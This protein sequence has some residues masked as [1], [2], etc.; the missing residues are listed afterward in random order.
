MTDRTTHDGGCACRAVR[1]QV[2]GA[3]LF[4]HACHCSWCQ[5]ETG[6]AFAV[7]ALTE[8]DRIEVT[9]AT[10]DVV[11]TPSASGEGQKILRCPVC[12]V[13]VWS[14]YA[15]A[16]GD[17][18]SFLRV[19]TLDDPAVM[20]PDIHIFTST[21]Q[22]WLTLPADA[23]AVPEYYNRRQFWPAASVERFNAL[24]GD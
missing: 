9:G 3:P 10:P 6:A 24:R 2:H 18:V 11:L 5:R 4:V 15:M 7:N 12:R 13:A 16:V 23:R 8:T 22:P 17:R 14:H 20:P 19:G 1:Y 21:K